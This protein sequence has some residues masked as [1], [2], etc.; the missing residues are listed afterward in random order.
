MVEVRYIWL[1]F[2]SRI[3]TYCERKRDT[4]LTCSRCCSFA[5][6]TFVFSFDYAVVFV[7]FGIVI[8]SEG[9][10]KVPLCCSS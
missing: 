8:A 10:R 7:C 1:R 2:S 3:L 9:W 5:L 6:C 4:N